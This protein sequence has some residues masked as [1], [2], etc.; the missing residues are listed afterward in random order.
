MYN[1]KFP[2]FLNLWRKFLTTSLLMY[3]TCLKSKVSNSTSAWMRLAHRML[4]WLDT[5]HVEG[6]LLWTPHPTQVSLEG[7]AQV[8]DNSKTP[9]ATNVKAHCGHWGEEAGKMHGD[10][11]LQN[12]RSIFLASCFTSAPKRAIA[13]GRRTESSV[14]FC[15]FRNIFLPTRCVKVKQNRVPS[16]LI[17][18]VKWKWAHLIQRGDWILRFPQKGG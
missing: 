3:E 8:G 10:H 9:P 5:L 2:S 17:D 11:S 4:F 7:G 13:A 6:I 16:L 15:W 1:G 14:H 12:F 18:W